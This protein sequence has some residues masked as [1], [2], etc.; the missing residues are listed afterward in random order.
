MIEVIVCG[1]EHSGTTL[2]SD[3]IRQPGI[4]ES[5]FEVGVLLGN[6][7]REF[8]NVQPFYNHMIDGWRITKE[9][10]LACC[11]TDDFAEFYQRLAD[12]SKIVDATNILFDKTP[13]YI[14][15]L[16]RV[17]QKSPAKILAIHKDPRASVYSDFKRASEKEFANWFED[18]APK[19]LNYMRNCYKGY[20][21]GKLIGERFLSFS[22]EELCFDTLRTAQKIF[23][24]V[25]QKFE[26][27][28]LLLDKLRYKNTRTNFVSP[29]I[30]LEYKRGLSLQNQK[31][32]ENTFAEFDEWFF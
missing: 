25:E 6:S 10:L 19:K 24:H 5:G 29:K 13:R 30:L 1:M 2:V 17:A 22:L 31:I 16:K 23:D 20:L 26:I 28:Y 27:D 11:D 7:P 21:D 15:E 9:E 14:A 32:I 8:P 3:L 18:Y 4:L 12:A